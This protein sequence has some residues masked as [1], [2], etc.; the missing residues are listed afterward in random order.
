MHGP[1]HLWSGDWEQE[2]AAASDRL[3]GLQ[4]GPADAAEPELAPAKAPP[5]T[6]R[7]P[8]I[9]RPRVAREVVVV[10]AAALFIA[11]GAYG[12]SALLGSSGAQTSGSP[13]VSSEA[14]SWLGMDVETVPPGA[15]VVATVKLGSPGDRA[16]LGPGDVIVE[17]NNHA[18]SGAGDIARAIRGLHAGNQV[19]LQISHGSALYGIEATLAAPPSVHP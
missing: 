16:G 13:G 9:A 2:S 3:A 17:V 14:V 11:A 19:E 8:R 15:A 5:R 18:I 1:K 7:R 4:P 12:L 6:P 10:V